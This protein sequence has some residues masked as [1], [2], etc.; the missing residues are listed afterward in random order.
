MSDERLLTAKEVADWLNL[1]ERTV[2]SLAARGELAGAKI[3][4]KW[5]FSREDVQTYIQQ[6]KTTTKHHEEVGD[7]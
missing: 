2:I 3:A 6:R 5:R 7:N 1:H 4:N